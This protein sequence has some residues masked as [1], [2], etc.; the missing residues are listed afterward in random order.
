MKGELSAALN[1]FRKALTFSGD[2]VE[3]LDGVKRT[4]AALGAVEPSEKKETLPLPIPHRAAKTEIVPK[5]KARPAAAGEKNNL[6]N[7]ESVQHRSGQPAPT[8]RVEKIA[9]EPG[10]LKREPP[11]NSMHRDQ[12]VLVD[13]GS[14]PAGMIKRVVAGRRNIKG[15]RRRY[16]APPR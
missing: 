2:N 5:R 3:A 11:P 7:R 10:V 4:E 12:V 15:S 6:E 13:D 1:D 14:C 9:L 8:Q 16:C